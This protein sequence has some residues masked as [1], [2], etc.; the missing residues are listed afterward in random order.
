MQPKQTQRTESAPRG[1]NRFQRRLAQLVS[2]ETGDGRTIFDLLN[3]VMHGTPTGFKPHHRLESA[4][5][6]ASYLTAVVGTKMEPHTPTPSFPRPG[7]NPSPVAATGLCCN[8]KPGAHFSSLGVPVATGMG[9]SREIGARPV[10]DTEGEGDSPL[11]PGACPHEEPAPY[12]I[13]A[14]SMP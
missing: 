9:G 12:L 10:P 7:G 11:S 3:G 8:R 13:R 1:P 4:K 6:L 2:D 14:G 5:E